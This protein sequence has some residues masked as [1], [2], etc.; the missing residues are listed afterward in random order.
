MTSAAKLTELKKD[1]HE[2]D[3]DQPDDGNEN[4]DEDYSS[5]AQ[6]YEL[7]KRRGC[8]KA[9]GRPAGSCQ[10]NRP[11]A[12]FPNPSRWLRKAPPYNSLL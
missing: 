5:P 4:K 7:Q 9:F 12:G 6:V 2:D 8:S 3:E 10:P 11:M 1:E